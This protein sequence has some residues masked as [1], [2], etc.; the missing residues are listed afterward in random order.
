MTRLPYLANRA[1]KDAKVID[2][3]P[4]RSVARCDWSFRKT[5]CSP[6]F[7]RPTK[8][9]T[10]VT[11]FRLPP[12][13]AADQIRD[14]TSANLLLDPLLTHA[15]QHEIHRELGT[16]PPH[17]A[18]QQAMTEKRSVLRP[19]PARPWWPLVWSLQTRVR[20]GDDGK[21]PVGS[22]RQSLDAA[23]RSKVIRCFRPDGDLY[24][25][26]QAPIPNAKPVILLHQPVC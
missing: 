26:R 18:R 8:V 14:L 9:G 17:T 16:T 22:Q 25:L 19:V 11:P 5:C 23:P 6:L 10:F 13:L 7:R 1:N 3:F 12:L 24:Y 4:P 20:V 15:N 21:V 2:P